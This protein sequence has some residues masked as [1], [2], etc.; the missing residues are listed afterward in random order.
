M[1][2]W[3][4]KNCHNEFETE[5]DIDYDWSD[6]TMVYTA[7]CMFCGGDLSAGFA[8]RRAFNI[9][10]KVYLHPRHSDSLAIHPD[11]VTEHKKLFPDVKIDSDCRPVFESFKQ[12]DKY[13]E[14]TGFYKHPQK[15]RIKGKKVK[16]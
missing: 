15:T 11:Q 16:V 12:E 3:R 8:P 4:C 9:G 5:S 14:T 2:K 10:N 7:N 1:Y 6:V 13:L